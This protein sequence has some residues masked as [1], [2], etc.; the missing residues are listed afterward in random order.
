[1]HDAATRAEEMR[2]TWRLA[3]GGLALA[4]VTGGVVDLIAQ[5]N[6]SARL[7]EAAVRVAA[8]EK[9]ADA[10]SA[11]ANQQI[12]ATRADAEKQIAQARQAALEAGIV[13]NVLAAPDLVRFNLV[14]TD[15]ASRAYAQVL[16][17]RSRGFVLSASQLPAPADGTTYQVWLLSE[18]GPASVG[19]VV[20][21]ASGRATLAIDNPPNLPRAVNGVSVTLE[22][23]GAQPAP[24]SSLVLVRVQQ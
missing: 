11:A 19:I 23:G 21:D 4:V 12:T 2:R 6:L 20:P 24:S 7:D 18:S 3:I 16:W 17:S 15:R 5:R 8:A 22:S 14:G 1:M 9:R 10:A 13:G